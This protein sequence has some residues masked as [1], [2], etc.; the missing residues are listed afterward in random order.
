MLAETW[1]I[2]GITNK[3]FI[4][5]RYTIYRRDRCT[6]STNKTR[7]GGVLVAVLKIFGSFQLDVNTNCREEIWIKVSINNVNFVIGAVYIPPDSSPE[8]YTEHCSTIELV[9]SE[10]SDS[11]ICVVGDFNLPNI[12]WYLDPEI[13]ISPIC[14]N[15]ALDQHVCDS[16]NFCGL[17][18]FNTNPNST[19]SILD[20][21]FC[22][23]MDL[24]VASCHPLINCDIYH[25]ALS[26]EFMHIDFS[27]KSNDKS[28]N[29]YRHFS[30]ASYEDINNF[31][32]NINWLCLC[33]ISCVDVCVSAFYD[34][35]STAIDLYVPMHVERSNKYPKWFNSRTRLLIN[36]KKK[37]HKLYKLTKQDEDY[38]V[39]SSLRREC[40]EAISECKKTYLNNVESNIHNDVRAFWSYVNSKKTNDV[41]PKIMCLENVKAEKLPDICNL[42]ADFF[43]S[44]YAKPNSVNQ[45]ATASTCNDLI[46]ILKIEISVDD[47]TKALDN[48]DMNWSPGADGLPP[49]F[50]K[51]CS[52]SLVLPLKIIFN[53]SLSAGI[54]PSAWKMSDVVPIHKNGNKNLINNY[55]GISLLPALPKIFDKIVTAKV[56]PFIKN[57]IIEEQHGFI[58]GK[59]TNTNLTEFS[60]YLFNNIESG[61]I[62]DCIHTDIKKAFDCVNIDKLIAKL[63]SLGFGSP[64]LDWINSYLTSRLQRVK[65]AD[66]RSRP[67]KVTSGVPQGSHMGPLLF[68]L[69]IN[70]VSS[71]FSGC[72]FL[73]FA[74]DLK[75]FYRI[76]DPEDSVLL[77]SNL[78]NFVNWCNS[79]DLQLNVSKCKVIRFSMKRVKTVPSYYIN[80]DE[81][82]VVES[83]N[84]LGVTFAAN[85][86]FKIHINNI[87]NKGN[88]TLGFVLRQCSDFNNLRTFV[89][90]YCSL[91]RS[92]LEY[93]TVIWCPYR[94][95]N[96]LRLEKIQKRFI[97]F[98]C[99]KLNIHYKA[100]N[101]T[102]LLLYLGLP[103]LH[104]RRNY[105]DIC[106]LFK[107]LNNLCNCPNILS[108]IHLHV[109]SRDVRD[110]ILFSV[111]HHRTDYGKNTVLP[112]LCNLANKHRHDIEFFNVSCKRFKCNVKTVLNM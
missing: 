39:F 81:L 13:G 89:T 42:F 112:R 101:Y 69:F 35:I 84:D 62:V 49:A 87:I 23:E 8:I 12:S 64:F 21:V 51:M 63:N 11:V 55:R 28:C 30:A 22:N 46:D 92:I 78:T 57:V 9:S 70:D 19:G 18:Q 106:F 31:L 111:P 16:Y 103:S 53:K 50:V 59:S 102:D 61:H 99:F 7:G 24:S 91:V 27:Q 10:Y 83:I 3:E 14:G 4:D 2:E 41:I 29:Y 80:S 54:F 5:D 75:L 76:H 107:I 25:P 48:I 77:Q 17:N 20:L 82:S 108:M 6:K 33:D 67:I 73:L 109:P 94:E 58:V 52:S 26:I 100:S 34:I 90:L 104:T 65:I 74:D 37:A 68:L 105:F 86:D 32:N 96:A 110:P 36:E 1:L 45:T 38:N 85:L 95:T 79:N 60:H 56:L 98:L 97:R 88:K 43:E 66:C 47:I 71:A 93:C 15:N 72:R 40:K 44:I